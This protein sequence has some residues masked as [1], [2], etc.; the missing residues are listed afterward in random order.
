MT[1]TAYGEKAQEAVDAAEAENGLIAV[2]IIPDYGPMRKAE[3]RAKEEGKVISDKARPM[4]SDELDKI[5]L[6]EGCKPNLIISIM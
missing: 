2:G 1:V 4:M 3:K 5:Q 6:K